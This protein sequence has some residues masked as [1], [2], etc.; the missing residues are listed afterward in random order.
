MTVK[1]F[2]KRIWAA[3]SEE[4]VEELVNEAAES[5]WLSDA[6]FREIRRFAAWRLERGFKRGVDRA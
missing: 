2:N 3:R 6:E 5:G 1:D 4:E